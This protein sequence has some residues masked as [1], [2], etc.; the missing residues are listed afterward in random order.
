MTDYKQRTRNFACIVYTDSA[1]DNWQDIIQEEHIPCFISP[2]HDKDINKDGTMKKSHYHVLFMF[3]SVK[4]K[5]QAED[6]FQKFGG[7]GVETIQ[8]IRAYSRYLC[9]LDNPEKVQ[10]DINNVISLNGADYN[11]IIFLAKDKYTAIGEMMDYCIQNK[12]VSYAKLLSYARDNHF[13]WFKVLCDNSSAI[14]FQFLKSLYWEKNEYLP[15]NNFANPKRKSI[16]N[17]MQEYGNGE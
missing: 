13:D 7:V 12:I 8:S 6:A 14:L 3:D 17:D 9:H 1:P 11:S 15:K 4:T 16:T 5:R 10:Y 2:L